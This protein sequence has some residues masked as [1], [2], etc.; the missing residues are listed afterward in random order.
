MS[1]LLG[2]VSIY[3][4]MLLGIAGFSLFVIVAPGRFGN[5]LHDSLN[6]F[7][8]VHRADWGKRLFLRGLGLALLAFAVRVVIRIVS[9]A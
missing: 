6:L 2:V 9:L 7:P 8:E 5:L 4:V 1:R 3:V